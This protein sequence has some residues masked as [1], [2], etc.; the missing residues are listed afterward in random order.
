VIKPGGLDL[1]VGVPGE[2]VYPTGG[3]PGQ[4]MVNVLYDNR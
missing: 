1:A 2:I 4:G 3:L